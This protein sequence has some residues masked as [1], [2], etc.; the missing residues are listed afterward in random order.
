MTYLLRVATVTLR[1]LKGVIQ[2]VLIWASTPDSVRNCRSAMSSRSAM[3]LASCGC[4]STISESVNQRIRSM[5]CTARSM[6]TPT[7]DMRGGNGPTRV[8]AIDRISSSRIASLIASTVGLKR[9][10]WPTIRATPARRAPAM[11]A[12]PSST[13]GAIGFSTR[14]CTP[15]SMHR[16]ASSRCRCVG[17]AMVTASTPSASSPSTQPNAAQPSAPDTKS[18]CLRSGSATPTSRTPGRS[19]NTRAWLL[20]MTPT[21]TTPT[22]S[23]PSASPFA[24]CL[25]MNEV[26]LPAPVAHPS[27]ARSEAAGDGHVPRLRH[28]LNQ[29]FTASHRHYGTFWNITKLAAPAKEPVDEAANPLPDRSLGPKSDRALEISDIGARFRHVARLHRQELPNGRLADGLLDQPHDLGD[30]DRLAVADI[31]HV[32]GRAAGGR[33][34]GLPR[35]SRV[36]R[37][38][39][40]HEPYDRFD[41]VVDIGEVP[42]HLAVVEQLDRPALHDGIREQPHGHVRPAPRPV[43]G[44]EPQAGRR[45]REQMRVGMRHQLVGLLGR[46]V[47]AERVIDVVRRPERHPGIGAVDR[48]GRGVDEM[49]AAR[50]PAALEHVEE[51]REVGR[52]I[53]MGI[54]QGMPHPGLRREVDDVGEAVLREQGSHGVTV[55]NVGLL[56]PKAGNDIELRDARLLQAR[57]VIGIEVV[58]TDHAIAVRQKAASHVHA[59]ESGR[60]GH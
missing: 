22:R 34:R 44:E 47:E 20:P 33:I 24:D 42:A 18:H 46:T 38:G 53:G 9:S 56:E 37:R 45:Q 54:D 49:P 21:P 41:H 23:S 36:R 57:V 35:P 6:T 12:R 27:L 26:P 28:V 29:R 25:M 48:R 32:P 1:A 5:S 43:N 13:D 2:L 7:F 8:I 16:S 59:D 10:T 15:R 30:L 50:V 55:G 52:G 17:A 31:V 51:A 14:T 40:W 4:T 60:P 39:L 11:M 19:A 58:E 3:A